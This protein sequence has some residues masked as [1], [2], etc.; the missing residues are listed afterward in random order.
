MTRTRTLLAGTVLLLATSSAGLAAEQNEFK[1]AG[2]FVDAYQKNNDVHMRLFIR[3][4]GDGISVYNA[5]QDETD[6]GRKLYCPPEKIGIVDAQYVAIMSSFLT[7]YP[8]TRSQPVEVVLLFALKDT[9]PCGK[10]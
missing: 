3:G 6:G 8:K 7:K 10:Q 2:G 5:M 4:I 9:F 1:T